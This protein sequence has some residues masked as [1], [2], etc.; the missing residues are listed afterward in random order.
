M[1]VA[2]FRGLF[3]CLEVAFLFVF[4]YFSYLF[5]SLLVNSLEVWWVF[6]LIVLVGF[7]GFCAF[8]VLVILVWFVIC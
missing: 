4:T 3:W 6:V 7:S 1:R 8:R 5:S 2:Y